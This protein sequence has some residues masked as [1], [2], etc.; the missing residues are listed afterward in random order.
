[1]SRRCA[2]SANGS[3]AGLIETDSALRQADRWFLARYAPAGI[4]VDDAL[5]I[6]Q[7]RGETGPY[8]AP[9]SGPPSVSLA[10]LVRP[11]LLIDMVPALEEARKT[12]KIARRPGL[13]V[14]GLGSVDLEVIPLPRAGV[15]PRYLF[16]FED[17]SR[18]AAGRRDRQ[19]QICS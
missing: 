5:N 8:L 3:V 2:S 14:E 19:A 6:L 16:V 15:A 1:M 17:E 4:L 10:R 18:R 13:S 7:F 9:A 12:G 11:E